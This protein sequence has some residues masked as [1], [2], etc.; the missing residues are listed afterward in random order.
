MI[1]SLGLAALAASISCLVFTC[2]MGF[3]RQITL[4]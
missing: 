4:A 2:F 3:F 1:L